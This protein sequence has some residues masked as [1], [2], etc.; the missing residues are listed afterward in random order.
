MNNNYNNY[1]NI[2]LNVV[3]P[4]AGLGSRF[5]KYGFTEDKYLLPIDNKFTTMIEKAILTLNIKLRASFIF[6][7]REEKGI[8]KKLRELLQNI[9]DNNNYNCQFISVD[10]L[11]E[12]PASSVYFAKNIINNDIPLIVSNSDQILD[13]D[14]DKFYFEC[15]KYDGCVLTYKPNYELIIGE[16]DKHSFVKYINNKPVE[17]SEK[18]I[19]SNEALVGVHYY[20]KGKYFIEAYEYLYKNNIR[21][22]NNEFYLSYTYQALL[23]FKKYSIG[24]SML[25]DIEIF[26]PVGEPEDYFDYYNINS[27][28][29]VYKLED[30]HILNNHKDNKNFFKIDYLK[31]KDNIEINNELIIN[32]NKSVESI[33]V[34][35]ENHFFE[36]E[37]DTY[38]LRIFNI[39]KYKKL[40]YVNIDEYIRGWMIGNFEP[41]I[42][43]EQS[44]EIGLLQHKKMEKWDF[45][46]HKESTEIN[47]LIEGK[48]IINN[49][50]INSGNIFIINKNI[51]AC[52][53]FL[54]DCKIICI[55]IPSVPR[56][57]YII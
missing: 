5:L 41:A 7:L 33:F 12:G 30:Y 29:V 51:I 52:P 27:S 40:T 4:M 2:E 35:G 14:F 56:D 18:K 24:S 26:Y 28:I 39:D 13:W 50:E 37:K 1:N 15:K 22:P 55:K 46:Y 36:S 3:I 54:E 38:I 42:K 44:F 57:K 17:F 45:H 6:I 11:T 34:T 43:K 25:D 16:K 21:A 8:N 32:F 48:M 20:K 10:K 53:I 49:I 19:I 23:E 9:C 47:I 31:N